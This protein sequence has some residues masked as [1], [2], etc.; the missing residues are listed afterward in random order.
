M[1]LLCFSAIALVLQVL[2]NLLN[3]LL[4]YKYSL[5]DKALA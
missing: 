4:K 5:S 3:L 2:F 1:L